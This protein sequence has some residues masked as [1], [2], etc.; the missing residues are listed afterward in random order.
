M[1]DADVLFGKADLTTCDREQIHVPG[2][3]Q[4]Y[5]AFIVLDPDTL[6]IRQVAGATERLLGCRLSDLLGASLAAII[7]ADKVTRLQA[8]LFENDVRRP[9]HL[10]DFLSGPNQQSLDLSVHQNEGGI[11]LE[12][13]E[14]DDTETGH[15]NPLSQVQT[16]I[17]AVSE[18]TSVDQFCQSATDHLHKATGYDRVMIYRFLPDDSGSVVAETVAKGYA[19]FL[20]LRYPASDIPRQARALYLTNWLRIVADVDDRAAPLEPQLNPATSPRS[21]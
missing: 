10:F 1:A 18:A 5:G 3:V 15:H 8:L 6:I 16:M 2:S 13:E 20:G 14:A 21:T 9:M 11:I 17:A 12:F 7:P 19:S 4:S